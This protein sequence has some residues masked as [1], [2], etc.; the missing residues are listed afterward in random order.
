MI[1]LPRLTAVLRYG[2]GSNCKRMNKLE[3]RRISR[4]ADEFFKNR[5]YKTPSRKTEGAE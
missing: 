5:A 3:I 4:K 1:K 2:I